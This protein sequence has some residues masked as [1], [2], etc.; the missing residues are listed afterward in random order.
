M[1]NLWHVPSPNEL[2][3]TTDILKMQEVSDCGYPSFSKEATN[4]GKN[5][6]LIWCSIGR[7]TDLGQ[8]AD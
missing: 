7:N 2:L 6:Q 4:K 3:L 1:S 8:R 5:Q